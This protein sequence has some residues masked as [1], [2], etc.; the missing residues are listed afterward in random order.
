MSYSVWPTIALD[1]TTYRTHL[2]LNYAPGFTLYQRTTSLNQAD[3]NLTADLH[4]A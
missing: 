4:I 2:V 1:K 3:Q